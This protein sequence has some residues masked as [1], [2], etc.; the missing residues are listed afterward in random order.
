M[1]KITFLLSFLV[2]TAFGY[3]QSVSVETNVSCFTVAGDTVD[4]DITSTFLQAGS[5]GTL[6]VYYQGDVDDSLGQYEIFRVINEDGTFVGSSI[7]NAGNQCE[8]FFDSVVFNISQSDINNWIGDGVIEFRAAPD[9]T[10]GNFCNPCSGTKVKLEYL[11]L[12]GND[13][14]GITEI[15][16]NESFCAGSQDVYAR[17]GNFGFNQIDSVDL[18]W[19]INGVAQPTLSLIAL[20]DTVGGTGSIDTNVLLGSGSLTAGLNTIKVYSSLPNGTADTTNINDTL[21]IEVTSSKQP[22]NL[23]VFNILTTSVD[24]SA[25]NFPGDLDYEFGTVGFTLGTGTPGTSTTV[26]FTITGLTKGT[27]YDIYVRNNCFGTDTSEWFGPLSFT[28]SFDV[29]FEQDFEQF[30]DGTFQNFN[31]G[32]T[33]NSNNGVFVTPRWEAERA[34]GIN[35]AIGGNAGPLYDHTD[36]GNPTGTHM[37]FNSWLANIGNEAELWTP[38]IF[39][40]SAQE[41]VKLSYWYFMFGANIERLDVILDT[42]GTEIVI[43]SLFGAQQDKQSDDW[44]TTEHFLEG[45]EGKSVVVKFKG[46]SANTL[47][48]MAIDDVR[49]DT[50][51]DASV[52]LT[53]VLA[54][55]G[56]LCIGPVDPMVVVQNTGLD[57]ITSFQVVQSVNGSLD[58]TS[59]VANVPTGDT[60]HVTLPT[61]NFTS[62]IIYDLSFY[63]INPNGVVDGNPLDDSTS[64]PSLS[65]GL[66]GAITI[67]ADSAASATNF[68]NFR[69]LAARLNEVGVC[70]NVY[71]T[72]DSNTYAGDYFNVEDIQGLSATQRLTIDG[73][74]R[75]DVVLRNTGSITNAA[76]SFNKVS[77]VTIKNMTIEGRFSGGGDEFGIHFSN[78]SNYDSLINLMIDMDQVTFSIYG[79]GASADVASDF[80]TNNKSNANFLTVMDCEI[81]GADYSITMEG[82]QNPVD[83]YNT[84]NHFINNWCHNFD[85]YAY[86]MD[87]SDSTVIEGDSLVDGRG[88]FQRTIYLIDAMNF[89]I[90]N[91]V[92]N[93]RDEGIYILNANSVTD[94]QLNAQIY[95]NMIINRQN[96][97]GTALFLSN[98]LRVSIWYNSV[99]SVD[100]S[101]P[102]VNLNGFTITDSIDLRNNIFVSE[103]TAAFRMS[104]N[105]DTT[106]FLRMDNNVYHRVNAGAL[107]DINGTTY[108]TLAAY[109]SATPRFNINSI[110]KDPQFA[111]PEDL[112]IIGLVP[113]D[114]ADNSVLV[115]DDIDG[116][117]RPSPNATFAD[118]GVDEYDPPTC[119][120]P[121]DLFVDVLE[122]D[123]VLATWTSSVFGNTVL[124]E[125]GV[126]GFALG[127]GILDS[128]SNNDSATIINLSPNSSYDIYIR[129]ICGRGDS[130]LW[131]GPFSFNTPCFKQPVGYFN[132]FENETTFEPAECWA[133]YAVNGGNNFA[134]VRQTFP[135]PYSGLRAISL[136]SWIGFGT[137]PDEVM[138]I[139]PR[140][141]GITDGDK[142]ITLW[143]ASEDIANVLIVA[144]TDDP[145]G[146][147]TLTD[148]DTIAYAQV[149]DYQQSFIEL[150]TAN[151]YNGTDEYV[152][153]RHS[154]NTD[155]DEI[156]IDDF[157]YEEIPSCF[158]PTAL[159]VDYVDADSA[160]ISWDDS[161][162]SATEWELEY[163]TSP[164]TLG[165]GTIVQS[166]ANG[167]TITGL[168]ANTEYDIAVKAVCAIG[169]TSKSSE[170][171]TFRTE[172]LGVT[173]NT[174]ENWD[175][176]T[177][178]AVPDCWVELKSYDN[179]TAWVDNGTAYSGNNS[180]E[181]FNS[182]QWGGLD[183]L[184][185][186]SPRYTDMTDADKRIRFHAN[187]SDINND[188]IVY[189]ANGRTATSAFT[190]MARISIPTANDWG[191]S[192]T[193]YIVDLTAANGYNGTDQFIAFGFG[194]DVNNG[195]FDRIRVDDYYYEDIPSCPRP[196]NLFAT[197]F[198]DTANVGWAGNV[199]DTFQVLYSFSPFNIDSAIAN[200]NVVTG[201]GN[202][203]TLRNLRG[204][205]FYEFAV[206]FI[207]G[208]GDTSQYSR[209]FEFVTECVP[210]D[211][212][213]FTNF[214]NDLI[215]DVPTCWQQHNSYNDDA[216]AEV[217]GFGSRSF[218]NNL[219]LN[220]WNLFTQGVDTLMSITPEFAGMSEGNKRLRFWAQA[221][222]VA[223]RMFVYTADAPSLAAN[224]TLLD[225][226]EFTNVNTY[227]Q[228]YVDITTANGYNGTDSVIAFFHSLDGTFDDIN[229][230]DFN[231][232]Q[233]PSCPAPRDLS[234]TNIGSDSAFLNWGNFSNSDTVQITY[235]DTNINDFAPF[236]GVDTIVV[237]TNYSYIARNLLSNTDYV[238]AVRSICGP[239]DTSAWSIASEFTT[240]CDPFTAPYFTDFDSDTRFEVASCW[241]EY[242]TFDGG[243]AT[244]Q[245][246]FNANQG[247]SAPNG[248]V[249]NN[250]WQFTII[251]DTL[252]A[253]TPRFSDMTLGDKRLR[254]QTSASDVQNSGEL[255]VFTADV[256]DLSVATLTA[257]DTI[258]YATNDVWQSEVINLDAANGYNGTDEY[259][260]FHSPLSATF[261]R[262]VIDDFNYEEIPSCF[263][264]SDISHTN[265]SLDSTAISWIDPNGT[266]A[267][268]YELEYGL[269]GFVPGTGTVKIA[270][271]NPDTLSGLMNSSAY[272]IYIRAICTIG[273]TSFVTA[274]DFVTECASLPSGYTTGFEGITVDSMPPCWAIENTT[275]SGTIGVEGP[276]FPGNPRTGSRALVLYNDWN[277]VAGN[278]LRTFTPAFDS[279]TNADHRFRFWMN[280]SDFNLTSGLIVG[281]SLNQQTG[282]VVNPIDTVYNTASNLWEEFIVDLTT[283]N[284]YNGTDPH[285]VLEYELDVSAT[286]DYIRIDD[287]VYEKIPTCWP[288]LDLTGQ[289]IGID[290]AFLT[291]ND[292]NGA[293]EWEVE[294]GAAPLTFGTGTRVITTSDSYEIDGLTNATGYDFFVRAICTVGDTSAWSDRGSLQ[295][296]CA[297]LAP[298]SFSELPWH[299]DFEDSTILGDT[300][301]VGNRNIACQASYEWNFVT[302]DQTRGRI[303][304]EDTAGSFGGAAQGS[305]AVLMDVATSSGGNLVVNELILTLNLDSMRHTTDLFLS[306]SARDF[307]D[308]DHPGDSVWIRGNANAGDPWV[309]IFDVGNSVTA[310]WTNFGTFDID[311]LLFDAGQLVSSSFQIKLGQEDDFTVPTDGIAYDSILIEGGNVFRPVS[312]GEIEAKLNNISIYPNPSNGL[313]TININS[314]QKENYNVIVRDIKGQIVYEEN[315]SVNGAYKE[316]I[317]FT[318]FAKGVYFMQVQ[319]E[320]NS[321]VEKLV[322]Q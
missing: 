112:H 180:L 176:M 265:I 19:E 102:A 247:F 107:L 43:D 191:D 262:F 142:W 199:T 69:S 160:I 163:S 56:A 311:S 282:V 230:D 301:Y 238:F 266:A 231:Y 27:T 249:I 7:A 39:I 194:L 185:A 93:S 31:E 222:D 42:N 1:K 18:N 235:K 122:A 305:G 120:P 35:Q 68:V 37:V 170:I 315:V 123:S 295:T 267:P 144:T 184:R 197:A 229:I 165:S 280:S 312:V 283:A 32:W 196:Q 16:T 105:E 28:T 111:G 6:T 124:Y 225:T 193:E 3:A 13:N 148:I 83:G 224:F 202:D 155:F 151:G 53:E 302:T 110:G 90:N 100:Q 253:I 159:N 41:K 15:N 294:Y 298:L 252:S 49:I 272:D 126:D 86:F 65:T 179:G 125:V 214:D 130:S 291:W 38:P 131:T 181:L 26:P 309:G 67:N 186:V 133:Q 114:K 285:I 255:F 307:G 195:T 313:F 226:I 59:F 169:D 23:T 220:S 118:I 173:A 153:F 215:N 77:Y 213:Y 271:T 243:S 4:V 78:E 208:P 216:F 281:T 259:V 277:F 219:N 117:V 14:A 240:L 263:R 162:N 25:D 94:P 84:G 140:F 248:F 158:A 188:L 250:N 286:F 221:D 12:S 300:N 274:G 21:V 51:P 297:D 10:I 276:G 205:S 95:N 257:I 97:N 146:L 233:I 48:R 200:G 206:R 55:S 201:V 136:N 54:P 175:A 24:I 320:T 261:D 284:G 308:E 236:Q 58:T 44:L 62:G 9:P 72:V 204:G 81:E 57:T 278:V 80:S 192:L 187:T 303:F 46:Y 293:T 5:D 218:P 45:F 103:N 246:G 174:F 104:G 287:M 91:N 317:D 223:T 212:P 121:I 270:T 245:N 190:E 258:V 74:N 92:I 40:S 177:V 207:C 157:T 88:N 251:L 227:E 292:T 322:I 316:D 161:K 164:L 108:N 115:F 60:V 76:I 289:D 132:D 145:T 275:P 79:I 279:I 210:Y 256:P 242:K 119:P 34:L 269:A 137:N 310:T 98:P 11:G 22:E 129:E 89:R 30:T 234:A 63:T 209:T 318:E 306:F 116:E 135:A 17:V 70:G 211:E 138:T 127:S 321:Y 203:T 189:T 96:N 141:E 319:S 85:N 183:F 149:N 64:L 147:G 156:F 113:S 134:E 260:V 47:G 244:V 8:N 139:T 20:L 152:T 198:T 239:A 128:S 82:P 75:D 29:P 154:R 296:N 106:A 143:T 61:I 52:A 166:F 101:Q 268:E 232:E 228:Y 171:L 178:N 172:C 33:S 237:A 254:F 304:T 217:R 167:D 73:V 299:E 241:T 50:L 290:S 150:T 87:N 2:L 168:L 71:V 36:F 288:P 109:Q 314:E 182:W 66:A 99:Y 264:V 273:D